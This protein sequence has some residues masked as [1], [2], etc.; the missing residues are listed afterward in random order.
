MSATG[1]FSRKYIDARKKKKTTGEMQLSLATSKEIAF[2]EATLGYFGR[3]IILPIRPYRVKLVL[4]FTKNSFGDLSCGR[5]T[6]FVRLSV[7][8]FIHIII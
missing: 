3:G 6:N 5:L 2:N 8:Y 1:Q 4:D 7:I